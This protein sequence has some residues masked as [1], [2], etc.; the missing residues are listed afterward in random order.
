MAPSLI[1][2]GKI[3]K[4]RRWI[5]NH[6]RFWFIPPNT[7]VLVVGSLSPNI[8]EHTFIEDPVTSSVNRKRASDATWSIMWPCDVCSKGNDVVLI[9]IAK[10]K[11]LR[12][13]RQP[14]SQKLSRRRFLFL[15][16]HLKEK[17]IKRLNY[18]TNRF[19]FILIFS[20]LG[21]NSRTESLCSGHPGGSCHAAT[22]AS[23]SCGSGRR[24]QR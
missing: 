19:A 15:F 22:T 16:L 10:K 7:S 6:Q 21:Q 3:S 23:S 18:K 5:F 2:L 1:S 14:L 24:G 13:S 17:S 9:S 4:P 11:N 12:F 20:G 8:L